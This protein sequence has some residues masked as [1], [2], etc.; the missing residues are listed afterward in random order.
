MDQVPSITDFCKYQTAE[1]CDRGSIDFTAANNNGKPRQVV[2]D[3][4][5]QNE[6]DDYLAVAWALLSSVGPGPSAQLNVTS[7]IAA[8][9]SFRY[10][11]LP[12]VRAQVLFKKDM[13]NGYSRLSK[14]NYN[15]LYGPPTS[16]GGQLSKLL[17]LKDVGVTPELMIERDNHATWCPDRGMEE[18]YTTIKRF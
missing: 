13:L 4:D 10:R 9:F 3:T 7:I 1:N 15:F 18:S 12:L 6:V 14:T 8:P 11:F 2:I 17:R 16:P 5:F